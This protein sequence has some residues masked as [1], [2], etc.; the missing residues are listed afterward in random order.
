MNKK[1]YWYIVFG[2]I[3]LVAPTIVYLCFL[4]PSLSER[5]NALM[6]SGGII[7]GAG[8]YGSSKIPESKRSS[9]LFKLAANS[10]TTMIIVL[11]VEEF[12]KQ[13]IGLA[14]TVVVSLI[15]FKILMGLYENGK[16]K[17]EKT[18]F[19]EQVARNITQDT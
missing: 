16:R 2:V 9:G 1:H 19:A 12:I 5:Y 11:M 8:F 4:I 14:A 18:E 17:R 7:G 3:I 10:F 13:I 15:L 6:S